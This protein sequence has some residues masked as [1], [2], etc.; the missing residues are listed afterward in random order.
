MPIDFGSMSALASSLK[1]AADMTK[2][3]IGIRDATM[4]QGKILELQG[5]ILSAQSDALSAQSDQFALLDRVRHLEKEVADMKAWDAA[6]E[7]YALEEV[8]TGAFAY[9]L[10]PEAGGAEPRHW[11]CAACYGNRKKSILQFAGP[12]MDHQ[13]ISFYCS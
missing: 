13:H 8:S 5:I 12:G 11:L 4:I 10:K 7:G 1:M 9:V 3:M 2:A 6:K